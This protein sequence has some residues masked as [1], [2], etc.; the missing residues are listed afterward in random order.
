[1]EP[2][3]YADLLMLDADPLENISNV[4]KIRLVM[5]EGVVIDRERLPEH[6]IIPE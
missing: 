3:K 4:R 2:E 1:M 6:K 5:K